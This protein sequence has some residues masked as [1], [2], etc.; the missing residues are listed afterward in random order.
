M[1]TIGFIL[2]CTTVAFIPVIPLW[3]VFRKF[4]K[5]L[6]EDKMQV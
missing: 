2:L 4:T 5:E 3:I 6:K 1:N